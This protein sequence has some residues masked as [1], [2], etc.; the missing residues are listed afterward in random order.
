MREHPFVI[1][2]GDR[3]ANPGVVQLLRLIKLPPARIAGGVEMADVFDI[4]PNGADDIPLHDLHVVY[5][6]KQLHPG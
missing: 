5:V 2:G 6:V 1:Q 4:L 3:L